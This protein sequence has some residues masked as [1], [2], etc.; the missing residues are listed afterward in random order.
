MLVANKRIDEY[1]ERID[2]YLAQCTI[3]NLISSINNIETYMM[4]IKDQLNKP[5]TKNRRTRAEIEMIER[6]HQYLD[7]QR[8]A[9]HEARMR[10]IEH[11]YDFTE[12]Q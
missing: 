4:L 12:Y 5:L 10:L 9:V 2:E 6:L 8:Q 3:D 7:D 1:L 11:G